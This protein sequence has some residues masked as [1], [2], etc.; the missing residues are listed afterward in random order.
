MAADGTTLATNLT[1]FTEEPSA[2]AGTQDAVTPT[3]ITPPILI[4]GRIETRGEVDAYVAKFKKDEAWRLRVQSRTLGQELDP[5]LAISDV[6]GKE[7][8]RIDDVGQ[9]A[10]PSLVWKVPADG[11]YVIRVFDLHRRGGEPF[12]Y[13][14]WLEPDKPEL[15]IRTPNDLYKGKVGEPLE[16]AIS[17]DR[18]G[19]FAEPVTLKVTGLPDAITCSSVTSESTGDSAKSMKLKLE[20]REPW[21]GPV[22]I[23]SEPA[24]HRVRTETTE[25]EQVW[26]TIDPA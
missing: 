8:Q 12:L 4:T 24:A 7:F 23:E 11:E 6:S 3:T 19:G 2:S 16:L 20:A 26:I 13:R 22:R 14:L 21:N 10:D 1:R 5:V 15:V 25:L 9:E 17:L 18:R